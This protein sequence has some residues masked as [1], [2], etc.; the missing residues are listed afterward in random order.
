M[1]N[2][3]NKLWDKFNGNITVIEDGQVIL[4]EVSTPGRLRRNHAYPVHTL[5]QFDRKLKCM[6]LETS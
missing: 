3:S 4:Y 1:S 5:H 2:P 6:Y